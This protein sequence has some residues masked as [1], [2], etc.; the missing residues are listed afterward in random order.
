[1][2]LLPREAPNR[3]I[4]RH[5]GGEVSE[6]R[7]RARVAV[8][9]LEAVASLIDQI[10]TESAKGVDAD[11]LEDLGTAKKYL[12]KAQQHQLRVFDKEAQ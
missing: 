7:E 5:I 2:R 11:I 6:K 9:M 1:M 4:T 12:H 10:Y 3:R 8:A